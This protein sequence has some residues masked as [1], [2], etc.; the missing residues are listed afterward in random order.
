MA[1]VIDG[2]VVSTTVTV[3]VHVL[4]LLQA[5]IAAQVRVAENVDPHSALVVVP[6][7]TIRFVPQVSEDPV[8]GSN[9]HAEP[10]STVLLV[11]Q[12]IEGG[13]VSTTVTV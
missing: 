13:V 7:I 6:R 2:A 12:V 8:G 9:D 5:S 10:Q 1:Q 3:C 11:A 4:V